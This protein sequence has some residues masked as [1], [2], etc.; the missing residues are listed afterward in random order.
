MSVSKIDLNQVRTRPESRPR[1]QTS[2]VPEIEW[3]ASKIIPLQS[4]RILLTC[5][6]YWAVFVRKTLLNATKNMVNGS[7]VV[8]FLDLYCVLA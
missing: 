6:L 8:L 3:K 5:S 2:F 4:L 7:E 1:Q